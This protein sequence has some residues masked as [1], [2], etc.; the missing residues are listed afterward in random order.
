MKKFFYYFPLITTSVHILTEGRAGYTDS[1]NCCCFLK[2]CS[3]SYVKCKSTFL[4]F[5]PKSRIQLCH[6]V[7]ENVVK[8]FF[9]RLG[10]FQCRVRFCFWTTPNNKKRGLK[11]SASSA[12]NRVMIPYSNPLLEQIQSAKLKLS[13]L[14][15]Q[16][17]QFFFST[18]TTI[19]SGTSCSAQVSEFLPHIFH[20]RLQ[21]FKRKKFQ[22]KMVKLII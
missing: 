5:K 11:G 18:S 21:N 19:K 12:Q 17:F 15:S 1:P 4:I 6:T 8:I 3:F 22:T 10:N 14:L 9:T 7:R 20:S 13:S 16:Y 2:Q